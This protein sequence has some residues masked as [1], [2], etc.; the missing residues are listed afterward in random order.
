MVRLNGDRLNNG[1]EYS[2]L[3]KS[4]AVQ[5]EGKPQASDLP[6]KQIHSQAIEFTEICI[7]IPNRH[8]TSDQKPT[9]NSLY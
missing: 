6:W 4:N 5:N 8:K 7:K 3:T 9:N 1:Y 2:L